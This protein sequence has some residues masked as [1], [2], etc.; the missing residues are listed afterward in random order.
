LIGWIVGVLLAAAGISVV[1]A[2]YLYY[3]FER[4]FRPSPSRFSTWVWMGLAGGLGAIAI[5]VMLTT[6]LIR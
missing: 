2:G 3:G 1:Y 6:G 4:V 5:T